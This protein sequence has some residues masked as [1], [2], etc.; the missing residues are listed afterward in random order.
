MI[1]ITGGAGF[2]GLNLVNELLDMIKQP[3]L[4]ID[5]EST[6]FNENGLKFLQNKFDGFITH[7]KTSIVDSKIF[8][9]FESYGVTQIYHLAACSH[10]DRSIHSPE[11]F[12]Y[13]NTIGTLNMLECKRRNPEIKLL[14]VSTDEVYGDHG[15]F[16]TPLFADFKPSS[17]YS[18]SK[19]AADLISMSYRRTY[20]LHIKNSWCCN[21]FGPYQHDE[22]FLPTIIKSIKNGIKIPIYGNGTN[23]RQ[24]VPAQSHARRL[25]EL[26][27]S[28]D[29][30][31]HVGGV[32]MSNLDLIEEVKSIA[33]NVGYKVETEFVTDRLGHDFKYELQDEK[34]INLTD[35]R[36]YLT[37]YLTTELRK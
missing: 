33:K 9:V 11:E 20:G 26:M 3:V 31:M 19:A 10:V 4:I 2:I 25:I 35:F 5:N 6:G 30:F 27:H 7:N 1:A 34:A 17:P 22:K 15:P 28:E 21:N 13:T 8:E 36:Y 29:E 37:Q 24:W 14:V 18:S 16:P 23:E 12:V 32:C